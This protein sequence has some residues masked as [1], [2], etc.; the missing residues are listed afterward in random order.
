MVKQTNKITN[1]T[2]TPVKKEK[3]KKKLAKGITS[4]IVHI[5]ASFN[6][7]IVTICDKQGKVLC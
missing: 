4:G 2:P 1:T 5:Q 7:T 6:N 3:T